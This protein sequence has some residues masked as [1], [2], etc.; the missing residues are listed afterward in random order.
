MLRVREYRTAFF[1]MDG[2]NRYVIYSSDEIKR[3]SDI[4]CWVVWT[5]PSSSVLT[6]KAKGTLPKIAKK[7]PHDTGRNL[8]V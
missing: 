2:T 1:E 4:L 6:T 3:N 7:D 5:L 8:H